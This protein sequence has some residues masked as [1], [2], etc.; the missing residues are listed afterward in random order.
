[1]DDL[2]MHGDRHPGNFLLRPDNGKITEAALIDNG[3]SLPANTGV[4]MKH[5]PGPVENQPISQ[6]NEARLHRMLDNEV[7]LRESLKDDL[8]PEAIDGLFA[9]AKA[10]LARGT[11]GNFTVHEINAHLPPDKQHAHS[12][13]LYD[14]R[15]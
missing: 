6:L 11:Y 2:L 7:S 4:V 8:E 1:M 10:L 12:V 13:D 5:N 14:I 15:Q 9:R 3:H